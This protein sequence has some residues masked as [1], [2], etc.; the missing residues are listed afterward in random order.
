[1]SVFCSPTSQIVACHFVVDSMTP[2]PC[3]SILELIS[4]YI[5]PK[6]PRIVEI[7]NTHNY[8]SQSIKII[9]YVVCDF[10]DVLSFCGTIPHQYAINVSSQI[11]PVHAYD[12]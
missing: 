10:K 8:H 7:S 9:L 5:P 1:M 4:A 3:L 12:L 2:V 11:I 6:I